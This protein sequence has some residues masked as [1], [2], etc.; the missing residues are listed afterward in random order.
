V[1][2]INLLHD[3][4]SPAHAIR[5]GSYSSRN[6]R[7][8]V[9]L[10]Q[11]SSG[12]NRCH[13]SEHA[14]S[15]F[16]HQESVQCSPLFRQRNYASIFGVKG[17]PPMYQVLGIRKIEDTDPLEFEIRLKDKENTKPGYMM[18]TDSGTELELRARLKEA[19]MQEPDI[20]ELF[21]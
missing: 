14:L 8:A 4:L 16:V 5:Y 10:R 20:E 7:P 17:E 9:V 2:L 1:P 18:T 19:G 11:L 21:K 3:P 15:R 12:K 13:D 6:P